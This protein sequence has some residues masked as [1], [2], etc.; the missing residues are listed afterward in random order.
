MNVKW[1]DEIQPFGY[2]GLKNFANEVA[3]T[4]KRAAAVAGKA[5]D[6]DKMNETKE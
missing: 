6:D 4:W 3:E 5:A 2:R 1:N